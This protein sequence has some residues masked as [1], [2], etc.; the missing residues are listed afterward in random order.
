VFIYTL[1]RGLLAPAR[2]RFQFGDVLTD[3]I[4]RDPKQVSPQRQKDLKERLAEDS[5]D[6]LIFTTCE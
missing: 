2:F 5:I 3:V 6:V 4:G 1:G